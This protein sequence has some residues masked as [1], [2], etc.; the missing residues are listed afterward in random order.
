M[1]KQRIRIL[2][3]GTPSIICGLL[4]SGASAMAQS[5]VDG[6][7]APET[8]HNSRFCSNRTLS[9]D[10]G[11]AGGGVLIGTP[12]LPQEAQFRSVG[13]SHFDGKGNFTGTE[14]TVVNG[15]SLEVGW[16][17]NSGTYSVNRNCT[18]TLVLN[19][20]DSPVPLNLF[21]VVVRQGSEF[22]TVLETSAIAATWIKVGES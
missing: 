20:P 17:A 7:A 8:A 18:G 5:D 1:N 4:A 15:T 11:D 13:V 22:H 3:L 19:T 14:H 12:G 6:T 16:T 2:M 9:C 10:Y 21:F